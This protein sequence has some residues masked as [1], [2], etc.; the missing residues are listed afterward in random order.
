MRG[1]RLWQGGVRFMQMAKC[2]VHSA[3]N[4]LCSSRIQRVASRKVLVACVPYSYVIGRAIAGVNSVWEMFK[5]TFLNVRKICGLVQLE[6]WRGDRYP[7]VFVLFF[8]TSDET[9]GTYPFP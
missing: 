3:C 2:T 8:S 9:Y 4:R 7:E 1:R 5:L 6:S